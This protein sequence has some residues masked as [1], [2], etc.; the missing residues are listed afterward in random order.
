MSI[1]FYLEDGTEVNIAALCET[2]DIPNALMECRNE[3]GP[4]VEFIALS[5]PD[6]KITA[7]EFN[8]DPD[9]II[10]LATERV[11]EAA[12]RKIR[13]EEV[14][15]LMQLNQMEFDM[16]GSEA[17]RGV[18]LAEPPAE[19]DICP[20]KY[21]IFQLAQQDYL[22]EVTGDNDDGTGFQK[23]RW[24]VS[25]AEA[26][27]YATPAEAERQARSL[28]NY[29]GYTL[30]VCALHETQSSYWQELVKEISSV[31]PSLN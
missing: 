28:V 17:N 3:L 6:W 13:G 29:Y 15:E 7:D 2:V 24:A 14:P 30:A 8:N 11:I 25:P 26:L 10:D 9:A 18:P 16:R 31:D 19:P 22:A 21:V 20:V 5:C 1:I 23:T 4:E 12:E 27:A